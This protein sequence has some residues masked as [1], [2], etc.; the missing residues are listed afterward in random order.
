M[1]FPIQPGDIGESGL[2][3]FK[4]TCKTACQKAGCPGMLRHDFRLAGALYLETDQD[5]PA[6]C[7]SPMR[8]GAT[9]PVS[10]AGAEGAS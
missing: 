6:S 8:C 3:D 2:Q 1:C 9:W 10:C 7:G 5:A 4:K